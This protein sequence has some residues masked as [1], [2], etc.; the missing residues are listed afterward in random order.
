MQNFDAGVDDHVDNGMDITP[1]LMPGKDGEHADNIT[2][3]H[4]LCRGQELTSAV[5]W[6]TLEYW[7][8]PQYKQS[9][10]A[11]RVRACCGH[12]K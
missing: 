1:T 6:L 12:T 3:M 8:Q 2:I 11:H 7:P 4:R 9:D 5:A 10:R